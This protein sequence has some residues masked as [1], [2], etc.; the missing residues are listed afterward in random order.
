MARVEAQKKQ[1]SYLFAAAT[2]LLAIMLYDVMG[3]IIKHLSQSYP[4]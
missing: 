1:T 3:A 4:T 2:I